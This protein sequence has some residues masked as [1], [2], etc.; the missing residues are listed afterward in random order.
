MMQM[1]NKLICG[2]EDDSDSS[3]V[4]SGEMLRIKPTYSTKLGRMYAGPSED[5]L[6]NPALTRFKG[7]VQLVFTSPPFPLKRRKRYG[8][9]Q[10]EQYVSWL[11]NFAPMLRQ[12]LAPNGS[13]VIELGNAWE[14]GSPTMS[15]FP[16]KALLSFLE[17]A[18]LYLCQEFICFNPARLPSPAQWVTVERE[19]VKDAFTRVWWM[20]PWRRPKASNREVL[21]PYSRSMRD[22]LRRGTYNSGFRP[23]EHHIGTSSFLTDNGGAIPSNVLITPFSDDMLPDLLELIPVSNTRARDPYLEFCKQH[24]LR[25]HPAR[26]PEK[27]V[28]FFVRF[29]TEENDI[30]MDPFAGSNV[31]GFVAE[32][33]RRRWISIELALEYVK[34]SRSRFKHINH[35]KPAVNATLSLS[36][37]R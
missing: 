26:M 16:M 4:E 2:I 30:V 9:L 20:S 19:R 14:P 24:G 5:I 13:I 25:P 32:G 7:K 28:E 34:A 35:R 12:Y 6:A 3:R 21:V 37:V 23:S 17:S 1:S 8:N 11:A 36:S 29:L 10:G 33:L 31:T 22:L 15:T 27:L 18:N